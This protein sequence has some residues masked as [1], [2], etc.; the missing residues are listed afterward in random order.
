MYQKPPVPADLH[1]DQLEAELQGLDAALERA[2][3]RCANLLAYR[4]RLRDERHARKEA[5][6]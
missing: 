1:D 4:Q 2:P 5:A 3:A 6:K